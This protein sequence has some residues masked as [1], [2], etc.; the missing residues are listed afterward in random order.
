ME[1][2][3]NK[4]SRKPNKVLSEKTEE[5]KMGEPIE[6]RDLDSS[7]NSLNLQELLMPEEQKIE[8]KRG[9]K[10]IEEKMRKKKESMLYGNIIS[11]KLIAMSYPTGVQPNIV[12]SL[13]QHL[14]ECSKQQKEILTDAYVQDFINEEIWLMVKSMLPNQNLTN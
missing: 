1:L 6:V 10:S 2:N 12:S 14:N 9:A 5:S 3:L 7:G 13:P 8:D 11:N 4:L